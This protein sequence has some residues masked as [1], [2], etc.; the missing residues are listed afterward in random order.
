MKTTSLLSGVC[1]GLVLVACGYKPS[2]ELLA[3]RQEYMRVE[4]IAS[5]DAPQDLARAK[6]AL[7]W[8]NKLD[9][10]ESGSVEAKDQAYIAMRMAQVAEARADA[11]Q[12]RDEAIRMSKRPRPTT[13]VVVGEEKK[14]LDAD[15]LARNELKRL[16]AG[17]VV[18]DEARGVSIR[19]DAL[20]FATDKSNLKADAHEVLDVVA[21]AAKKSGREV[22]IEGHTDSTGGTDHN[23]AL[24]EKRAEA[25]QGYLTDKGID[26]KQT[27]VVA[28][29]KDD[30]VA[31]NR[32]K[33]GRAQNRRV[34]IIIAHRGAG[35]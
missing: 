5:S 7:D 32:T 3:A 22:I 27:E 33:E 12:T 24:S 2:P 18:Q 4:R 30:P 26:Q 14:K 31:D 21:D 23:V 28:A 15:E 20:E 8:A 25:A 6:S 16:P 34:E 35:M 9:K 10:R 17:T 13:P 1:G 29:G 19:S 11:K